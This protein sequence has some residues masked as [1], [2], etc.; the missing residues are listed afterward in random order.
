MNKSRLE[1]FSDGVF[2]IVITLLIFD[3]KVP[4]IAKPVTDLALWTAIGGVL[5][6]IL[7]YAMTFVVIASLWINHHYLFESFARSV[8]R[9]VNLL[10]LL[11]L[12]FVAFIPFS[13]YLL[14]DYATSQPAEIIYGLNIFCA[15]FITSTMAAY[16]RNHPDLHNDDLSSR[17]IKQARVRS[18]VSLISYTLG[19]AATFLYAPL[20][21]L[22]YI[23]PV[24][25][26]ILPGSL[27]M[28]ERLFRFRLD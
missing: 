9:Q 14:G 23:L 10:N 7:I 26:N 28:A 4:I 17:I 11:Y 19:L 3:I 27:N 25:F 6:L 5:P 20:A 22:F 16:I 24:V 13:A 21:L 8:N 18:L 12:M 15:V 1:A 2:S